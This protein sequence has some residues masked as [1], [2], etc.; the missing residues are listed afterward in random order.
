M[1]GAPALAPAAADGSIDP[2]QLKAFFRKPAQ[3]LCRD[4]LGLSRG[5]L[6]E[7][8]I[9]DVEPL[10]AARE[11]FDGIVSE[12]VREA[13]QGQ[14]VEFPDAPPP[15]IS[16]SGRYASGEVGRLAW[17]GIRE[18]AQD[19][20]DVARSLPPFAAGAR[21]PESIAVDVTIDDLRIRG[22]VPNVWRPPTRS[23]GSRSAPPR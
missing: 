13:L 8:A 22:A 16:R 21:H 17:D 11:R 7:E 23:G 9:G 6:E 5:A 12:L 14:L 2:A 1:A 10:G 18:E 20:L 19:W 15:S 4:V 3:W